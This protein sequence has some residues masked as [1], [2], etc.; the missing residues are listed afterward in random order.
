MIASIA[1]IGAFIGATLTNNA[2]AVTSLHDPFILVLGAVIGAATAVPAINGHIASQVAA[3]AKRLDS[4][5]VPAAGSL[6]DK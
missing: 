5:N 4:L 2:A 6:P 3:N 1:V